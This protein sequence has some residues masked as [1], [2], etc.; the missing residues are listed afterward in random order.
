MTKLLSGWLLMLS[1]ILV[2]SSVATPTTFSIPASARSAQFG[3]MTPV[4]QPAQLVTSQTGT[5]QTSTVQTGAS[6]ED[7]P[8]KFF[9]SFQR[10]DQPQATRPGYQTGFSGWLLAVIGTIFY[11]DVALFTTVWILFT[12]DWFGLICVGLLLFMIGS[13]IRARRSR[14]IAL[15]V[16][17]CINVVLVIGVSLV[18]AF[19]E[20][21]P[22]VLISILPA[23]GLTW[24]ATQNLLNKNFRFRQQPEQPQT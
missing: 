24:L 2:G 14:T 8:S 7:Y 12:S 11:G 13:F 6:D 1:V 9:D 22:P 15:F 16:L 19:D 17:S 3:D 23:V 20:P 10:I 4:L 5:V 18:I 21:L